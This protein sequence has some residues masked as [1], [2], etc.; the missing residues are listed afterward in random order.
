MPKGFASTA[1][2]P[3]FLKLMKEGPIYGYELTSR[4]EK[5]T[6]GHIKMS[7]GTVYPFLRRMERRGLIKSTKDESSG[8]VYYE[9]TPKGKIAQEK[10]SGKLD[11]TQ[12]YLDGKL[13]GLL[14]VYQELYGQAALRKLLDKLE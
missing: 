6:K 11:E 1:Y 2:E 14:S 13:L 12:E 7:F 4:F 8:R 3:I 9:L 5:M 10:L